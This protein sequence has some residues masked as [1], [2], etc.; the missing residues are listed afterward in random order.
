MLS[1]VSV[2]VRSS[3]IGQRM[4]SHSSRKRFVIDYPEVG[5]RACRREGGCGW[6]DDGLCGHKY[7]RGAFGSVRFLCRCLGQA[8][9]KQWEATSIP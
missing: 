6:V 7:G 8:Y 1:K 5:M 9:E 3:C 2:G 4:G